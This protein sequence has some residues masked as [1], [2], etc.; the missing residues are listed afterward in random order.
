[1]C[2][3]AAGQLAQVVVNTA[4]ANRDPDDFHDPDRLDITRDDPPA[5]QTFGAAFTT[6]SACTLPGANSSTP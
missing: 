5:M 2:G 4:A 6:G 1:M 3:S